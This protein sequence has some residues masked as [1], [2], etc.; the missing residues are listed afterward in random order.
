MSTHGRA[1]AGWRQRRRVTHLLAAPDPSDPSDPKDPN[2]GA[3]EDEAAG[4]EEPVRTPP[5]DATRRTEAARQTAWLLQLARRLQIVRDQAI[6][7]RRLAL[8]A[9]TN[10]E[11]LL[12]VIRHNRHRTAQQPSRRPNHQPPEA[13]ETD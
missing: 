6:E 4:E 13:A 11:E 8:Y 5:P 3:R 10:T 7:R 12:F 2:Q 9:I 1:I